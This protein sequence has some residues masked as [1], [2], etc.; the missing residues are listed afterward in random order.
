MIA[1]FEAGS[2][3]ARAGFASSGSQLSD[4]DL[5]FSLET[6]SRARRAPDLRR[7]ASGPDIFDHQKHGHRK[8]EY[9]NDPIHARADALVSERKNLD[10]RA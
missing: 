1:V 7:W 3:I 10:Q 5:L 9:N 6:K 8:L 4:W 2:K